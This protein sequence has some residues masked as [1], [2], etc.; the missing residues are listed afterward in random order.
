MEILN[1]FGFE[2][3]LF[4]AQIVNFLIIYLLM[5]KFLYNPLLKTIKERKLKIEEGL[6]NTEDSE[7]L[8]AYASKK[9]HEILKNA[10]AEAKKLL[11]EAK[12]KHDYLLKQT[13]EDTKRRVE[14]MLDDARAQ[15]R[16]DS[17]AAEKRLAKEVAR[18]SAHILQ[19]S[20]TGFFTPE[21]QEAIVRKALKSL[22]KK[23]D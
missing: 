6:K 16:I 14:K 11:E 23:A 9:E 18:V 3:I 17:A 15:I 2:P 4:L 13:E 20:L 8:L 10:Q 19:E 7:K 22:K 21:D 1:N 12:A 5:K